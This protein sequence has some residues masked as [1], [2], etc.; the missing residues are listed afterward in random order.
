MPCT[1]TLQRRN[2]WKFNSSNYQFQIYEK[3]GVLAGFGQVREKD[4]D[5]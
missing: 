1:I 5:A 2:L 4:S 3:T